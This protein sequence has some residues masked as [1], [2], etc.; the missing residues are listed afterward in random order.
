MIEPS[1]LNSQLVCFGSFRKLSAGQAS[2]N[3]T[4]DIVKV[5]DNKTMQ[6]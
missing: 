3:K 5:N 1:V 4:K 2:V 6:N